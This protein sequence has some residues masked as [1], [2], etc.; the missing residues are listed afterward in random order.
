MRILFAHKIA[1]HSLSPFKF[2]TL[3]APQL[4]GQPGP[5]PRRQLESST[6][7]CIYLGVAVGVAWGPS[8]RVS[9]SQ[10]RVTLWPAL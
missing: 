1:V 3:T 10:S 2:A 5:E 9:L 4:S 7:L 6:V 8:V